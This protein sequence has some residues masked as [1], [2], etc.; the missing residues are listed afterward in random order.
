MKKILAILLCAVMAL[1]LV[2][3]GEESKEKQVGNEVTEV[4]D[5]NNNQNDSNVSIAEP[6]NENDMIIGSW[7]CDEV[8]EELDFRNSSMVT[9]TTPMVNI[10]GS[11]KLEDGKIIMTYDIGEDI[12]EYELSDSALILKNSDGTYTFT[13]GTADFSIENVDNN[14]TSTSADASLL[15]VV[16]YGKN[17]ADVYC[18]LDKMPQAGVQVYFEGTPYMLIYG[19]VGAGLSANVCNSTNGSVLGNILYEIS[20]TE[21]VFHADMSSY[22]DFSFESV[23]SYTVSIDYDGNGGERISYA[24]NNVVKQGERAKQESESTETNQAEVGEKTV[25]KSVLANYAGKYTDSL[26][27]SFEV[28]KD[29]E[30]G[31][32]ELKLY[33]AAGWPEYSDN[34]GIRFYDTP[35][36]S[37]V[38]QGQDYIVV[39]T[40]SQYILSEGRFKFC[41]DGSVEVTY[42][43]G[44][45]TGDFSGRFSK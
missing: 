11:Y 2:A 29:F 22:A 4:V 30:Y 40:I 34:D 27:N 41:S 37:S 15:S 18:Q 13:R 44:V 3:C 42:K 23:S 39:E 35:T 24:V 14:N 5:N 20:D 45:L 9:A 33:S 17:E 43:G 6:S 32:Y 10:S 31:I 38:K 16:V 12:Y 26:G 7:Y 28:R 19:D 1:S 21:V 25:D 36:I 8:Q